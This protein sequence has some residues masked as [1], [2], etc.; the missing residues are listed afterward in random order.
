MRSLRL[1]HILLILASVSCTK[2]PQWQVIE[3]Q[4]EGQAPLPTT[5]KAE[6]KPIKLSHG[7]IRFFNQELAGVPIEGTFGKVVS[8][9]K[10]TD[11]ARARVIS[12]DNLPSIASVQE[13][14]DK[15]ADTVK[16]AKSSLQRLPC[17][18]AESSLEKMQPEIQWSGRKWQVAFN[19]ECEDTSGQTWGVTFDTKGG[20]IAVSALGSLFSPVQLNAS[21]YPAG[22]KSSALQLL[23]L[24]LS[25]QPNY[26]SN[27]GLTAVSDAGAKLTDLATVGE[28]RPGDIRFDLVQVYYYASEAL[29]WATNSF[30]F[31]SQPLKIRTH[32]GYPD[33]TNAS[34]YYKREV[35]I[36]S[37]DGKV[38][39]QLSLDPSIVDHE[40]MHSVID[41]LARLPFEGEG[42]SLNEG[43]ADSLAAT[44]L[45][46]PHMGE[47]AYLKGPY[48]RTLEN[49][50]KLNE[51]TGALYGDSLVLSGMVWDLH[52]K[53]SPEI[54]LHLLEYLLSYLTPAS[55]FK[56]AQTLVQEW[57]RQ[58][59]P[60]K[61]PLVYEVLQRRGWL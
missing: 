42:G 34:F 51:R 16:R 13:A 59:D 25:P 37:G 3:W 1:G 58:E 32:V 12:E 7:E 9:K 55:D 48:Q 40:V 38:F 8:R 35:R 50:L 15:K 22:P 30:H 60:E 4:G 41:T 5:L 29:N 6:S 39:S 45:N 53:V 28:I 10:D 23:K 18:I 46:T 27:L 14:L 43:L 52:E 26:L 11:W 31:T 61:Q 44:W 54:S 19:L 2:T 20:I 33:N 49:N 56:V 24:T 36:G 47:N 17:P 21:L 57:A